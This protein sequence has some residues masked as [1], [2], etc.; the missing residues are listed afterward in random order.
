MTSNNHNAPLRAAYLNED[1]LSRNGIAEAM[2]DMFGQVVLTRIGANELEYKTLSR[3]DILM[4]P[5]N[6]TE[7]SP[8]PDFLPPHRIRELKMAMELH[9][10]IL[11][12][13]CA[14]SYFMFENIEYETREGLVKQR[15]GAGLIKGKAT[16]AFHSLTRANGP[17]DLLKDYIQASITSPYF[18][19]SAYVLNVNGPAFHLDASEQDTCNSFL[20]YEHVDGAAGIIK[21]FGKGLLITLGIHPELSSLNSDQKSLSFSLHDRD[22]HVVLNVLGRI[23]KDHHQR[24][25]WQN[26]ASPALLQGFENV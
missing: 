26:P 16:Q 17:P 3:L 2:Q 4:L 25:P 21:P 8:Y 13:T 18:K 1:G 14:P 12:T 9:G 20:N 23:I 7:H 11:L 10:L 5:G 15:K 24:K 19:G 22:R 6:N